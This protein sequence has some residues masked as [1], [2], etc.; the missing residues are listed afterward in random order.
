MGDLALTP[1]NTLVLGNHF[2][3]FNRFVHE[4]TDIIDLSENFCIGIALD[5]LLQLTIDYPDTLNVA[6]VVVDLLKFSVKPIALFIVA[7]RKFS[8]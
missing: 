7:A 5:K 4:I 8:L 3:I 1:V 2:E 6:R